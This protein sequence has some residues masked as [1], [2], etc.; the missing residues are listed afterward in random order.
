[1]SFS[2]ELLSRL[3]SI[4]LFSSLLP[5]FKCHI[6]GVSEFTPCGA[7][8]FA[9]IRSA[10][11]CIAVEPAYCALTHLSKQLPKLDE[12]T[13][14]E[15]AHIMPTTGHCNCESIK[16]TLAELPPKSALCYC[17]NCR[18]AGSAAFT[19][20]YL[21]DRKDVELQDPNGALKTYV[22][23]NTTSGNTLYRKFCGNCGS[24]VMSV[25]SP[26]NPM[27]ILKG[28]LFNHLPEPLHEVF[29]HDK[30]PWLDVKKEEAK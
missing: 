25:M 1:M 13:L 20:N 14:S 7:H 9:S 11:R 21:I 16:I 6:S 23:K 24:P 3:S 18:R 8:L 26:D 2:I 4:C 5:H 17:K 15:V 30:A 12:H 29:T 27:V 19:V 22:D 10:S 28:G